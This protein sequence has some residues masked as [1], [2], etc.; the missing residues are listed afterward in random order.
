MYAFE[1][2]RK[3]EQKKFSKSHRRYFKNSRKLL[4]KKFDDLNDEQK[5]QVNIMLYTS[6]NLCTAHF[7]KEDF[8]KILDCQD[9]QSAKKAMSDWINSAYGCG[10]STLCKMCENNAKLADRNTRFVHYT[11]YKRFY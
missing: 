6:P 11:A 9:R 10:H 2:V 3:E 1:S 4:L 7:Y 5:Q 8:L